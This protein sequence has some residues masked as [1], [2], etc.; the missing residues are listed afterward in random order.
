MDRLRATWGR[1]HGVT[2]VAV[3]VGVVVGAVLL[4]GSL[5]GAWHVVFGGFVKG[6]WRAGGFGVALAL[7]C[8]LLLAIDAA[9]LRAVLGRAGRA[10]IAMS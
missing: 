4:G 7:A 2:R 3:V 6:N 9:V 10:R 1:T 5:F 8:G